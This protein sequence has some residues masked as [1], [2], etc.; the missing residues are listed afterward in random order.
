ML[1]AAP[2]VEPRQWNRQAKQSQDGRV[3][4]ARNPERR[5]DRVTVC[6]GTGGA[7][8]GRTSHHGISGVEGTLMPQS[9]SAER[10][11]GMAGSRE[12]SGW[13]VGWTYFAALM[14]L[15]QG[16]WWVF[17]GFLGLVNDEFYVETRNY[18]F[19]FDITTWSWI[20]LLIGVVLA[21]AGLALFGG[22]LWARVAG[23]AVA[24]IAMF[25]AF[26]WL[27][28]YPAWAFMFIAVSVAVIWSLTAHG[29]DIENV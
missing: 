20:H 18:V 5:V 8:G 3:D 29:H 21:T 26:A 25:A 27:P 10:T 19:Q 24:S 9:Y 4:L 1:L 22:Y 14:L 15:A 28:Y 12:V 13:A 7:R 6:L 17:T 2:V 16:S 23:I 11:Q